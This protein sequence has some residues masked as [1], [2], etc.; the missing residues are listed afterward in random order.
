VQE[1][2]NITVGV[3]A[4][5]GS[6]RG[7]RQGLGSGRDRGWARGWDNARAWLGYAI[8]GPVLGDRQELFSGGKGTGAIQARG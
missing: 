6:E 3:S 8:L 1:I 7:Q 5:V 2:G 4:V